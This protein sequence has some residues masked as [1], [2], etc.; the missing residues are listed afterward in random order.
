MATTTSRS[1]K[2]SR[3]S[4][5]LLEDGE[6]LL[7][8]LAVQYRFVAESPAGSALHPLTSYPERFVVRSTNSAIRGRIK[9]G[10]KNIF[11]DSDDWRDPVIRIP[12]VSVDSACPTRDNSRSRHSDDG[13]TQ[14][15]LV[16]NT[17]GENSV[18][19]LANS[20]VFQR[21][22]GTDHPYVDVQ[23]KGK[24]IIT[25]LY[26]SPLQLLDEITA[27]L[28][29][30]SS[31]SR[32]TRDER[33]RTLVEERE[34]RIPFDITLLEHGVKENAMMDSAASAVY[35]MAR[36]P[37]RFRITSDNVYFM[38]IHGES[39]QAVERIATR[40]IRSIRRLR[41]GCHNAA[42][43]VGFVGP[44]NA[45]N[46]KGIARFMIS[47]Q[48]FQVREKAVDI[49]LKVTND[50]VEMFDRR[51]LEFALNKWRRGQMS[52]FDY[53]M[54][55][56]M[57]AGRSFNDLSQY[58]VFPWVLKDYHS[59]KLDLEK[60][61]SFRDLS[62]PIGAL[63]P[64]RLAVLSERYQDMPP[65]R[66]FYGTHYSTPA[67]IINYLVR[68]APAAMLRLQNGRFD[69]AD[70]LFH[71]ISGTWHGVLSNHGDVK[72]LIPEFYA[73]DFSKNN[74]SGIVSSKSSPGEF[75]D[76]VLGLDL[77]IRQDGKRVDGVELPPWANGSS[78][79]FVR[80]NRE[81]LESNYASSKLHAWIDLV[82]GVK[83][84][85]A[86]AKNVFYTD[87]ALPSSMESA[88]TS[89][90]TSEEIAQ[91]ETVYLE[92][93]RTPKRL[94]GHPHPPRFGDLDFTSLPERSK[95]D[96]QEAVQPSRSSETS[97]KDLGQN[98]GGKKSATNAAAE[99]EICDRSKQSAV[100]GTEVAHRSREFTNSWGAQS[101]RRNSV[102]AGASEHILVSYEPSAIEKETSGTQQVPVPFASH[103][104][105]P[106]VD[107][108]SGVE[109]LDICLVQD[110]AYDRNDASQPWPERPVLCT[111]W[112]DGHL[113]VHSETSTLRSKHVGDVCSVVYLPPG[114][115]VYG[116]PTGSIGMYY[117]DSGR[118]EEVQSAAH[119]AEIYALEY[120]KGFN[121]VI[122]GSKDAS[123]KIWRFDKQNHRL[124]TL[125]LIEELDAE[126][127]IDDLSGSIE[128]IPSVDGKGH[129]SQLLVAAATSDGQ[130]MAWEVD[131]SGG[132]EDFPE[133][134]WKSEC[135][136][137]PP[138]TIGH[139]SARRVRT[140]A[141][142]Y[143]GMKRRPRL[144]SIHPE[145]NCVRVWS[146]DQTK[147]ASAEVFLSIGGAKSITQCEAA[148][149][150]L[151]GGVDGQI[152]EFDGT[153]LCLGKVATGRDEV[154]GILLPE[155]SR[156]LYVFAGSDEVLRLNR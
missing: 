49:L 108:E 88:D 73:T 149:T 71:S 124:A 141:W 44:A 116:T 68:A 19:V 7:S 17:D 81:A 30:T 3:F 27:L 114:V 118:T 63:E 99:L 133:P 104:I 67:Y 6:V 96:V 2:P 39:S 20:A 34:S 145:E 98:G 138:N 132:K 22:L 85:S 123:I 120:V 36:A 57:A 106:S 12:L 65:P 48:S 23:I 110:K 24:H 125:R 130:L 62:K 100:A 33:L 5:L 40:Q 127:S 140:V 80:R 38:P 143:Q 76:N 8:D 101:R 148:R 45:S 90:M 122:S 56:N 66:F 60:E 135:D 156:C 94:F 92:F 129:T 115:A 91:I 32:R 126:S 53:L 75:L 46:P 15:D 152:S 155:H 58:P 18:L 87:V 69:T 61:S 147:M 29:I 1:R 42:L 10:T 134:V 64:K 142:L 79:L 47:F 9:I 105:H 89:K 13:F 83:S 112:S 144:A 72:E 14:S 4:L 117:I 95:L 78:E 86:D 51:E 43:E 131:V 26:T 153:G 82:F 151:I 119:D 84:G 21:E 70:R 102:L 137:K 121:V 77:G 41:H 154:R 97:K 111:I 37:G 54:Y 103:V 128:T 59:D 150:V 146:L 55:L 35:A 113:K 31:S 139:T 11:F 107:Q 52:N 74:T 50:G 93:G 16:D 25:P 109:I 28:Q 136:L